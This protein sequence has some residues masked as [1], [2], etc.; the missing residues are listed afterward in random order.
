MKIGVFG[1]TFNPI[2]Y[3]HLRA[4]E[5]VRERLGF[6]KILFVPSGKPPLKSRHIAPASHRYEMLHIAVR[7]NPAFDLSDIECKKKGKS[8]TVET[9]AELQERH[10]RATIAFILGIDAFLDIPNW[11]QPERLITMSDFVIISR[12]GY[13]FRRLSTSPYLSQGRRTVNDIEV[14]GK[15]VH[16]IALSSKRK[17]MLV[18]VTPIGISST[19]IRALLRSGRSVKY[20]LPADVQSYI[21]EHK[22]YV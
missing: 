7:N 1:G 3:G 4:A 6:D 5:E 16:V 8:Y 22:L 21:M 20:L 13:L 11:R 15:R 14:P 2:H 12:P 17:A 9:I 18:S 19:Q 10:P